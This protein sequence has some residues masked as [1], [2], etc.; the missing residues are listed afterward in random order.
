MRYIKAQDKIP[1]KLLEELQNYVDGEYLYIPRKPEA[2]RPWGHSTNSKEEI[3]R[4]NLNIREQYLKG[5]SLSELAEKFFL[6][7]KSISRIL[8]EMKKQ[9]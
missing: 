9:K 8:R 4:R 3:Y 2:K 6:T 7:E 1:G 5:A